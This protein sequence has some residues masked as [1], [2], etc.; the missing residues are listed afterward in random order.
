[1]ATCSDGDSFYLNVLGYTW[2]GLSTF[3]GCYKDS[4]W[5]NSNYLPQY[6]PDGEKVEGPVVFADDQNFTPVRPDIGSI[7]RWCWFSSLELVEICKDTVRSD[8]G[9]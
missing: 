6:F 3:D 9:T 8:G 5:V 1:M 2:D 7:G 4:G